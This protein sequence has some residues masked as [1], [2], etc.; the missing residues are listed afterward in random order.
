MARAIDAARSASA[1]SAAASATAAA[2]RMRA[3]TS[4]KLAR[5]P[6][7]AV[8]AAD[9]AES[10]KASTR[11]T[12]LVRHRTLHALTVAKLRAVSASASA[13]ASNERHSESRASSSSRACATAAPVDTSWMA[14]GDSRGSTE[15]G[16]VSSSGMR[17]TTIVVPLPLISLEAQL[18]AWLHHLVR[19]TLLQR[20]LAAVLASVP[21]ISP[22]AMPS[23]SVPPRRSARALPERE[24]PLPQVTPQRPP[25]P[26]D[27]RV[28][29][30][31]EAPPRKFVPRRSRV[32]QLLRLAV[33]Q[34][35]APHMPLGLP[36]PPRAP[37]TT[38][39]AASTGMRDPPRSLVRGGR[40]I[41]S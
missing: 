26:C 38:R 40:A 10:A 12:S 34:K 25:R 30:L 11:C 1:E 3:S 8:W 33:P 16:A 35:A 19:R 4:A 5:A 18:V 21:Q 32:E 28:E 14:I 41:W 29:V 13:S 7:S 36:R 15:A 39:A 6:A 27:Q 24:S 23:D 31:A 37:H 17:A 9:M 22:L 20:G 2:S